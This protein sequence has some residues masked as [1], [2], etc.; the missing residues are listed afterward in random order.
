[1]RHLKS[2]SLG[3]NATSFKVTLLR[4]LRHLVTQLESAARNSDNLN[5]KNEWLKYIWQGVI[6]PIAN[7]AEAIL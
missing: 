3:S 1:L 4:A 5:K 7:Y 6:L 2:T